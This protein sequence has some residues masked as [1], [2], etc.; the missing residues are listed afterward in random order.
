MQSGCPFRR[1]LE[2]GPG[3]LCS[4]NLR[5]HAP[6]SSHLLQVGFSRKLALR[7]WLV[8]RG[9]SGS[10][11]RKRVSCRADPRTAM[12]LEQG[13]PSG[14]SHTCSP[15]DQPLSEGH[16]RKAGIL[17]NR[18]S[19]VGVIPVVL[20]AHLG[21]GTMRALHEASPGLGV[22]LSARACHHAP[23]LVLL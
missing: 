9:G 16:I 17:P 11:R 12:A 15:T 10:G 18:L 22:L 5:Y 23:A 21:A 19:A 6:P 8:W 14:M 3:V 1:L 4:G 20:I 2:E 13:K 7:W